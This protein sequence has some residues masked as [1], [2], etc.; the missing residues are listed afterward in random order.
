MGYVG[1]IGDFLAVGIEALPVDVEV[2]ITA[3]SMPKTILVGLPEATV[4]ESV[5]RIERALVNSGFVA[6]MDRQIINLAPAELPKQAASFDLPI[7]LGLLAASG[8]ITGERFAEYAIVGELALDGM[9]RSVKGALSMA[10]AAAKVN[11]LRGIVVPEANA[12][13]AA[14]VTDIEVI[15]WVV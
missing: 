11:G 14:V 12:S 5:F 15:A 13:E 1:K 9:T 8:Q 7:A 4:K 2:D 6:P 3:A 10:M